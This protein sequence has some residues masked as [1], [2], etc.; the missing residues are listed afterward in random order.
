MVFQEMKPEDVRKALEGHK[1]ILQPALE[2]HQRFFKSLSCYR[3]GSEVMPIVNTRQLFRGNAILPNFLAK[4]RTCGCDF[5]PSTKI[6]VKG[7]DQ[8]LGT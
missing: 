2:E 7:P 3:C 8:P 5:E 1:N 4:C 6:E